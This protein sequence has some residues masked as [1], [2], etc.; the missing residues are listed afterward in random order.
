MTGLLAG[1]V[2]LLTMSG[3]AL[4][5]TYINLTG[6]GSNPSTQ[7]VQTWGE[8]AVIYPNS[9]SIELFATYA[10]ASSIYSTGSWNNFTSAPFTI[11]TAG[12]FT[13]GIMADMWAGVVG[14]IIYASSLAANP[15]QGGTCTAVASTASW[16]LQSQ[17]NFQYPLRCINNA[18]TDDNS[19]IAIFGYP[20]DVFAAAVTAGSAA[21]YIGKD[22]NPN[23]PVGCCV[24]APCDATCAT[25][26][27][28]NESCPITSAIKPLPHGGDRPNVD[29]N[30][31]T[32]DVVTSYMGNQQSDGSWTLYLVSYDDNGT[33]VG[34]KAL[35]SG[36]KHKD[37]VGC[38]HGQVHGCSG[39]NCNGAPSC[40]DTFTRPQLRIKQRTDGKCYAYV[41]YDYTTWVAAAADWFYKIR[42]YIYDL[43]T[44]SAPKENNPTQLKAWQ[45]TNESFA[46]NQWKPELIVSQF[47]DA[48]GLFWYSDIYGSCQA[49]FE[50]WKDNAGGL[51]NMS[52]TGQIG[53]NKFPI[54]EYFN[55]GLGEYMNGARYGAPDGNLYPSWA[56]GIPTTAT[57][58]N[59]CTAPNG[60]NWSFIPQLTQVTP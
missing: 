40:D 34:D 43:G 38:D 22:C 15:V 45:S 26:H 30:P 14:D 59:D 21:L 27:S 4:A 18:S 6:S 25:T 41:A 57:N 29:I 53:P 36:I 42:L 52:S 55:R 28:V 20:H 46:W 44:A 51:T 10:W 8:P 17:G 58:C 16:F 39:A 47:N 1:G 32:G 12:P 24:D 11:S 35:I 19:A 3:G 13:G 49:L 2:A 56:Q 5:Y 31:C 9:S 50:G 60:T 33:K 23:G 54:Q 48:I 7:C 37:Q